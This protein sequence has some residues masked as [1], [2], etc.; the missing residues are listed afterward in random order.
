MEGPDVGDELPDLLGLQGLPELRHG[1]LGN[2]P[3]DEPEEDLVAVTEFPV[4]VGQ[5]YSHSAAALQ[6]VAARAAALDVESLAFADRLGISGEGVA[7][8]RVLAVRVGSGQQ[9]RGEKNGQQDPP[10]RAGG[11]ACSRAP[12]AGDR[13]GVDTKGRWRGG[14]RQ[15]F[16]HHSILRARGRRTVG[17]ST[18]SAGL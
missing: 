12:F 1:A 18:A 2:L 9:Q 11:T 8:R 7:L 15:Y 14:I 17:Y 5:G 6:A 13:S 10:R 3:F 16:R 4:V